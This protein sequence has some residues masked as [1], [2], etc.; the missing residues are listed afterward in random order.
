MKSATTLASL[1]V[2]STA[3]MANPFPEADPAHGKTL[4]AETC[5]A[6]HEKDF[7][8][9]DGSAIYLRPDRRVNTLSALKSQLTACTTQLSLDL[10]PE[11]EADVGAYLNNRYYKFEAP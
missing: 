5:V 3:G 6:C 10:F 7:G 9:E 11:D 4:H 1:L 2:L 8:G